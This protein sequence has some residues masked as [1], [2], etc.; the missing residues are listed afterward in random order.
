[1]LNKPGLNKPGK[2]WLFVSHTQRDAEGKLLAV[3]IFHELCPVLTEDERGGVW[4][5][6]K[7]EDKSEAA[8]KE[9]AVNAKALVCIVTDQYFLREYCINELRWAIEARVPIIPV[10]RVEDKSRI[11]ELLELAPEDIRKVLQ[12][13]DFIDI[14]RGHADSCALGWNCFSNDW[15]RSRMPHPVRTVAGWESSG[16]AGHQTRS[17]CIGLPARKLRRPSIR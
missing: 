4:L 11:G 12:N 16:Y 7:M 3:E 1:M 2:F 9:G 5:D 15:Q 10:V 14:N 6:V 8:M 17:H 13:L